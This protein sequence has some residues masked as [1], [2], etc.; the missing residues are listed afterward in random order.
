[1]DE[2]TQRSSS[3]RA[4]R[5]VERAFPPVEFST[6]SLCDRFLPQA[7]ACA[8]LIN[9]WGLEF[10]AAARLLNRVGVY[11]SR[12]G[13]YTETEALLQR[14]LAIWEKALG[15]EHPDVARGLNNLATLYQT[16]GQYAKAQPLSG[17]ASARIAASGRGS[18]HQ[19]NRQSNTLA[20]TDTHGR[21]PAREPVPAH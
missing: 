14:A 9:Q 20:S 4:V 15:P 21:D 7:H 8:E 19:F 6:W 12:R 1:M 11:L 5:A 13:R 16:Q 10:P 17:G 3:E 2:A 18:A